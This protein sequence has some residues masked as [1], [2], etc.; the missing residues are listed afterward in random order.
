M[1]REDATELILEAKREKGLTFGAIAQKVGRHKVW[2]TAALMG[3]HPMNE[4]ASS[5]KTATA[6]G[7]PT[8]ASSCP[9]SGEVVIPEEG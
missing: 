2:T 7:S 3:Q 1:N 6:S 9:T 5:T 4:E 8:R